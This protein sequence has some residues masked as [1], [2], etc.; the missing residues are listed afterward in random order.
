[1]KRSGII[2]AF[3]LV[4]VPPL[5]GQDDYPKAEVFG[6]YSFFHGSADSAG[7]NLNGWGASFFAAGTRYVGATADFSGAYGSGTFFPVCPVTVILGCPPQTQS[8]AAYHF[9]FGPRFTFRSHRARPFAEALFGV[10]TLRLEKEGP[11]TGFAMGFG[12]GVDVPISK[13][14]AY[15]IFQADY[16]PTRRSDGGWNHD[17][18]V[19]T[20]IVF[21]FGK[22]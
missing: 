14:L 8:L 20:G 18:R 19:Q 13:R 21:T 1:M 6:G 7:H 17:F 22:K 10:S 5:R 3:I 16:I 4:F 2:I 15:R 12:G 11:Q 9:L